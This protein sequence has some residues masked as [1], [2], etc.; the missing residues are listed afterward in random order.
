M[1]DDDGEDKKDALIDQA[2]EAI[3]EELQG[4]SDRLGDLNSMFPATKEFL[5]LCG[6]T[7]VKELTPEQMVQLRAYLEAE[8]A[9]ALGVKKPPN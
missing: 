9:A 4:I 6:A 1:K 7:H 3:R 2:L 5:R 8:L